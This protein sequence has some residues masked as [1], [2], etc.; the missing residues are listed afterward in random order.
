MPPVPAPPASR[1]VHR[2]ARRPVPRLPGEPA[3]VTARRPD[4]VRRPVPG[5]DRGHGG[6]TCRGRTGAVHGRPLRRRLQSGVGVPATTGCSRHP[7][8]ARAVRPHGAIILVLLLPVMMLR[9]S[10]YPKSAR[11]SSSSACCRS[12]CRRWCWSSGSSPSTG[13]RRH[14]SDRILDAR[15]RHRRDLAPV[16]VP[17]DRREPGRLDVVTLTEAA[18]SLG[19]GW[20]AV[21]WRVVIP[22]LRRGILAAASS[23]SPWCS[24]STRSRRS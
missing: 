19:A 18:R 6:F 16:R 8:L 17:A 2:R 22:N 5:A 7:E 14:C 3:R 11:C 15:L 24:G 4:R 10:A 20:L 23:R 1:T 9:S 13:D 21:L 12:R